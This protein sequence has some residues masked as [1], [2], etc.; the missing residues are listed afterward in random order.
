MYCF[1]V[2]TS[3]HVGYEPDESGPRSAA[4]GIPL[5]E[6]GACLLLGGRVRVVVVVVVVCLVFV[7]GILRLTL[8]LMNP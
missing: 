7:C 3:V 8:S 2:D 6:N 5:P 4:F 1:F